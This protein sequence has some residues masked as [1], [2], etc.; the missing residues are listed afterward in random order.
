MGLLPIK[1]WKVI[2][3]KTDIY[4]LGINV[5][6]KFINEHQ[7]DCDWYE[8]GKF[9]ASSK[10]EDKKILTNFFTTSIPSL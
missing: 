4:D 7:V 10:H 6:K 1:N 3:K 2:K 8:G 5:V 9:F